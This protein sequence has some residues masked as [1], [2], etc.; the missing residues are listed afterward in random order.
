MRI[1]NTHEIERKNLRILSSIQRTE[2][3]N[4]QLVFVTYIIMAI[5][6]SFLREGSLMESSNDGCA[7]NG[8]ISRQLGD[9]RQYG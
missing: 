5:L 3:D 9:V 1:L 4:L 6:D 7:T 8:Q 2:C